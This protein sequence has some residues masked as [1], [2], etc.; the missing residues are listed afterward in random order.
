MPKL[1]DETIEQTY[2]RIVCSIC[3]NKNEC[4]EELY[5][6]IDGTVKCNVFNSTFIPNKVENLRFSTK[7]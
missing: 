1:N 2:S 7:W 3:A 4:Q 6:K 5:R